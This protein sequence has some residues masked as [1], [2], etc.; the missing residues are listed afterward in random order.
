MKSTTERLRELVEA[1]A[2][3]QNPSVFRRN[4]T[5]GGIKGGFVFDGVDGGEN[6]MSQHDIESIKMFTAAAIQQ[7]IETDDLEGNETSADRLLALMIG[8]ADEDLDGEIGDDEQAV[9]EEALECAWDYLAQKGV[10]EEDIDALLNDFDADAA[11]RVRDLVASV[12]PEGSEESDADIDGFAFGSESE[13]PMLDAAY[14]MKVAVRDGKKVRVRKRVSGTIRLSAAQKRGLLK[15][16][17]KA[18]SSSAKMRR[19][20]SMKIR[21]KANIK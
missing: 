11:E 12:L 17:R 6:R 14:K 2:N 10:D 5:G 8:I 19:K 16:R 3:E 15:A 21:Q 7:W 9:L 4:R 20:K 13:S 18:H 1:S